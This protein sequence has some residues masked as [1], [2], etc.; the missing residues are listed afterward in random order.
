[1]KLLIKS[2][3]IIII[4]SV[5]T[6]CSTLAYTPRTAEQYRMTSKGQYWDKTTGQIITPT[7]KSPHERNFYV[8]EKW[9]CIQS[10]INEP[11]Y[12]HVRYT[13]GGVVKLYQSSGSS[14][15]R[16]PLKCHILYDKYTNLPSRT[17]ADTFAFTQDK[18]SKPHYYFNPL[19]KDKAEQYFKSRNYNY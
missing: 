6:P 10:D 1:M 5:L 7:F 12:I 14:F 16:E 8:S 3:L 11:G 15:G 18:L 2:L 9:F 13:H 17:V 19:L 4:I